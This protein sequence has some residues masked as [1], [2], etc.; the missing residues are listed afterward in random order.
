MQ[1]FRN[2]RTITKILS[3]VATMTV[4]MVIIAYIGYSTSKRIAFRMQDT[5]F[6]YALV[7]LNMTKAAGMVTENRL[8]ATDMTITSADNDL[9]NYENLIIANRKII[10]E[11]LS[12]VDENRLDAEEKN[13]YERI[14]EIRPK[15]RNLQNEGIAA[16]K[17][18]ESI[19]KIQARYSSRGDIG[20]VENEY[21][22]S[23][24]EL[25]GHLV[26]N[27]DD[28]NAQADNFA[29]GRAL[30]IALASFAA[31]VV[32][33]SLSIAISR[34][35][36]GPIKKIMNSIET[37]SNG[38]LVSKFPAKGKDELAIMGRTL[39]SMTDNLRQVIG[40][41]KDASADILETAR[42]F[43]TLAEETSASV[44]EFRVNVDETGSNLSTLAATSEEVNASVEEVAAGAQAT[45]EKGTGIAKRVDDAMNAGEDGMSSVQRAVSGIEGVA[46]NAAATAKSVRELG[47]RTKK[48]QNFVTQ[49]GGIADQTNLLALNAAIEAARAGDAGRGFAVVAEEVRKL[50]EE[51]NL[52]AKN[53][54]ELAKTITGDLETVVSMSVDNTSAS[55][56]AKALSKETEGK[57]NNMISYLKEI[58]GSTQDLAAVSEEQ[59]ASSEEIAEAV[60][61]ISQ[62]VND[63]A[64]AGENIRSAAGEVS[65]AAERIARGAEGL[66]KLSSTLARDLAFFKTEDTPGN[67]GAARLSLKG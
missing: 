11:L 24:N 60:Q 32:G 65:Q 36:T 56:N 62:R 52:A 49:I 41:V 15:Y 4:L 47:E 51:S 63:T 7:S 38:D 58:A 18:N 61:N 21:V 28:T 31:I 34:M 19:E 67:S 2:L 66:S 46:D 64:K 50:A 25:T 10:D 12:A 30:A 23:L 3:I 8:L 53:I 22:K 13:V 29:R 5:Y 54:E 1:W 35:I 40:A 57:I 33:I 17:R 55:E 37:F 42:E 6:N 39:Q 14:K 48:I 26:K 9:R 27:A 20:S 43:S 16:A 44:D 59:A 45:A